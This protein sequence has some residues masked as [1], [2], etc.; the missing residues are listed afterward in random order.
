MLQRKKKVSLISVEMQSDDSSSL[1]VPAWLGQSS[2]KQRILCAEQ[3]IWGLR[4]IIE[5]IPSVPLLKQA[6]CPLRLE[7]ASV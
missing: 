6:F 2:S 7:C 5:G 4:F 1:S 3:G